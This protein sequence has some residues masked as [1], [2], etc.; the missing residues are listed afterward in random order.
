M[1]T[2]EEEAY[3]V[4]A[5]RRIA[6]ALLC[7]AALTMVRAPA[8]AATSA[9][10]VAPS[11]PRAVTVQGKG[12]G[13]ADD[14]DAIQQALDKAAESPGGGIVS[15]PPVVTASV[16]RSWCGPRCACSAPGARVRRCC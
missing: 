9:F 13:R 15:F 1:T 16:A 4:T 6:L 8:L 5:V 11:E 2:M 10:E 7:V 14:T 12:D 3:A